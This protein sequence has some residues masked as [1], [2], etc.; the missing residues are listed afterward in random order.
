M[1]ISKKCQYAVRAVFELAFRN[2]NQPIRIS[3]IAQS[4]GIPRRFLEAI[5]NQLKHAGFV[6]SRRGS[7]G[8]YILA[9]SA[10]ELTVGEII[11][12]M[13][14]PISIVGNNGKRV[15]ENGSMLGDMA[16]E[17]LWETVDRAVSDV[18]HNMSVRELVES[19]RV[20]KSKF[21]PNYS[22]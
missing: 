18:F 7:T 2:A 19:E 4:Q 6:E 8:G 12:F 10:D 1:R 13:E 11:E 5:M 21:V 22:I 16:F 14:G 17:H 15:D 9:R 3:E 20:R